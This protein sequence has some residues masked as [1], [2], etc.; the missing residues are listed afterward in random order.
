[1]LPGTTAR[2]KTI[3]VIPEL[4]FEMVTDTVE[5]HTVKEL[6]SH[7]E[8]GNTPAVVRDE[9]GV[10]F[11]NGENGCEE[12]LRWSLTSFHDVI[13][14][15]EKNISGVDSFVKQ[16][17]NTI[18]AEGIPSLLESFIIFLFSEISRANRQG[19]INFDAV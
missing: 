13:E 11:G 9:S 12:K 6:G 1:M 5:N 10:T 4:G 15:R 18:I 16:R 17:R 7:R 2:P 19:A 8:D 3:L 14:N